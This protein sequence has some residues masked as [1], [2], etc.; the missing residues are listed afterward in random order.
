MVQIIQAR[1][2]SLLCR[3]RITVVVPLFVSIQRSSGGFS[4]GYLLNS[5]KPP[6]PKR[7]LIYTGHTFEE[8]AY[9]GFR[10]DRQAIE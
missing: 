8:S 4:D 6:R 7:Q 10:F 2:L 9:D 5:F 1:C 3:T